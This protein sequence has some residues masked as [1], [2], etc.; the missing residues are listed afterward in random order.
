MT[1]GF[2]YLLDLLARARDEAACT[3]AERDATLTVHL[4]ERDGLVIAAAVLESSELR[5]SG[6]WVA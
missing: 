5:I 2:C 1:T 4:A 3:P 6:E